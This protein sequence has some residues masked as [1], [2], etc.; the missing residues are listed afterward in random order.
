[1]GTLTAVQQPGRFG[2]LE[3]EGCRVVEFR[4]KPATSRGWIN[5]GFFVFRRE[6]LGR[7][8]DDPRL[9]FEQ[10]P[11]Q[12]LAA[13]GELMAYQHGGF[14]HSMDSSRDYHFLNDLWK[15]GKAPWAGANAYPQRLAG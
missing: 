7:L 12:Q 4:E 10:A 5:G 14:W 3:Q 11:L 2:E 9:V 6:L 1:M 13:D 8:P 15:S